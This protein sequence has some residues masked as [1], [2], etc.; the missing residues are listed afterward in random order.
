MGFSHEVVPLINLWLTTRVLIVIVL[1]TV[2]VM[3]SNYQSAIFPHER[4][5]FAFVYWGSKIFNHRNKKPI[6][7][8]KITIS[9]IILQLDD[10][11]LMEIN[12]IRPFLTEAL[13]HLHNLRCHVVENPSNT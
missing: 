1:S 10:L 12:M 9:F 8:L 7:R 3:P 11:S 13:D 2:L 6:H 5:Y 4:H